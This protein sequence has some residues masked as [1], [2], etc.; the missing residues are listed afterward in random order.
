MQG[1]YYT[2]KGDDGIR[3]RDMGFADPCLTTW[4]RRQKKARQANSLPCYKSGRR[5]SN[6]WPSPW[7][8]DVLPLNH[9]RILF[10]LVK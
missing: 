8:G 9:A 3:T 4:P 6:P 2:N 1:L 10:C 7:Q 5:D